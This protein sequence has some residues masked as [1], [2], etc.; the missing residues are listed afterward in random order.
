MRAFPHR[1]GLGA[2]Q[3]VDFSCQRSENLERALGPAEPTLKSHSGC[4][5]LICLLI[6]RKF[7]PTAWSDVEMAI[8]PG[9]GHVL[10]V[11]AQLFCSRNVEQHDENSICVTETACRSLCGSDW[12]LTCS[13]WPD[14]RLSPSQGAA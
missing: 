13:T 7:C 5:D 9:I 14:D 8:S 12:I 2:E 11:D 3:E 6:V 4:Y 1:V 10:F